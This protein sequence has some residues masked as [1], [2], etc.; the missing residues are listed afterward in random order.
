MSKG[1][2]EGT[3]ELIEINSRPSVASIWKLGLVIVGMN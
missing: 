2:K 3:A 1:S